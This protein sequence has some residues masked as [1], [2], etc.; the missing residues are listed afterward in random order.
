MEKLKVFDEFYLDKEKDV[1]VKL[2]RISKDEIEYILETPNHKKGTL[3]T[4]LAQICHLE[5]EKNDNDMKI[6][7][8]RMQAMI[9]GENE[10]VYTFRLGGIKVANIYND[11]IEIKA[12]IPAISK[13][14]MSQTKKY[15]L[16]IEKTFVKTYI[17]KKSKFRTDLHTHMNAILTPDCLIALGIKH[18]IRYP[19]YYIKKL[20]LVMSKE[21]EEKIME[22][23]REVEKEFANSHLTGKY[24]IRRIDD[25]TFINFA[26][27]ILNNLE[28]AKRNI[29]KEYQEAKKEPENVIITR[30]DIERIPLILDEKDQIKRI[31]INFCNPWPKGKHHKKRLTHTRQLE[32][33]KTFLSNDGEIFFKTDDDDLYL[34]SLRYFEESEFEIISKTED[35]HKNQIFP[36]N[37]VTEH[38]NMFTEQGITTK[39]IIAK[40]KSEK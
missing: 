2:Y 18:Q 13:T 14:L 26:D 31:Y 35:L 7:K 5:T 34:A 20:N 6:I 25:N 19:L 9:N 8:G 28:N 40:L 3:I 24:L 33:Y 39:A 15:K 30:F 37:I 36:E 32:K 38:E 16:P 23:R 22:Q 27:F 1:I 10:E 11:R 4:N 29:E 17:L 21:Q 12:Q